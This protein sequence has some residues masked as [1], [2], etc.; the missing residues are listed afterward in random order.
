MKTTKN[1][2]QF[3]K[4]TLLLGI[5]LFASCQSENWLDHYAVNQ[6]VKSRLTLWEQISKTEQLSKFTWALKKT[7]YDKQLATEQM[8]TVWAPVDSLSDIDTTD[9]DTDYEV[10]LKQYIQNHISKYSF[11]ASGTTT[12]KVNLLNGKVAQFGLFNGSYVIGDQNLITS[13]IAASNGILHLIGRKLP[14]FYNV[15]ELLDSDSKF[16]SLSNYLHTYDRLFFDEANSIPGEIVDGKQVYLDSVVYNYNSMFLKLGWLN[17]EDSTY[18]AVYPTNIAWD[19][20]YQRIKP[21]YNFYST[22]ATK[23]TADTLQRNYTR[24]AIIKDLVFR[25][26]QYKND[27]LQSTSGNVLKTPFEGTT[28]VNA[29]NGKIYIANSFKYNSWDSWNKVLRVEAERTTGRTPETTT[30]VYERSYAGVDTLNISAKKY[31]QVSPKYTS[32]KTAVTFEIPNTLSGKLNTDSTT[33]AGTAYNVY[34]VFAPNILTSNNPK[35]VYVTFTLYYTSESGT[36]TPKSFPVKT[37]TF[38]TVSPYFMTKVLVAPKMVFPYSEYGYSAPSVK[39]KVSSFTSKE[40]T[41]D[42]RDMLIDCILLEPVQQ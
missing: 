15:W 31:L 39:L 35:S 26:N 37:N 32:G 36:V 20:A 7:G 22:T 16:D 4:L 21:F 23:I 42:T 10:L 3:T 6:D 5:A 19:E 12:E 24:K 1:I 41:T 14:F 33:K 38:F 30:S 27:S 40:G 29:S 17:N 34:C 9:I 11:S 28:E 2:Y 18:Y 25:S 8:F 13:N